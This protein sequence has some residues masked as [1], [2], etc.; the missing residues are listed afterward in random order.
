[1]IG[2]PAILLGWTFLRGDEW[3]FGEWKNGSGGPHPDGRAHP[4]SADQSAVPE[5]RNVRASIRRSPWIRRLFRLRDTSGL[6]D[7]AADVLDEMRI[8]QPPTNVVPE[9]HAIGAAFTPAVHDLHRI[10]RPRRMPSASGSPRSRPTTVIVGCSASQAAT[11]TA[12][13]SN[14]RSTTR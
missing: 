5:W 10:R 2:G 3:A 14:S 9:L 6:A 13:R 4:V 8:A 1:M 7:E 12:K 11:I